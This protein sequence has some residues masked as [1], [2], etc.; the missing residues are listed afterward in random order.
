MKLRLLFI[1][2]LVLGF[3]IPV[4]AQS[5][6]MFDEV[7]VKIWPEYDKP[8]V[9]VILNMFLDSSVDLPA[10]M[11]VKIPAD[12]GEPY[13][14]AVRELDGML[15]L[16]E[17]EKQIQGDWLV[18]SFTTPYSEI[19]IEYYDP[20]I[21]TTASSRGY[22]FAWPGDYAVN[23]MKI[24]VQQPFT[25]SNMVFK[26]SMGNGVVGND[27][28]VYYTS[29]VGRINAGTSFALDFTYE[30]SDTELSAQSTTQQQVS[31]AQPVDN[32]TKGRLSFSQVF[33]WLLAGLGF[34]LVT[35]GVVWYV[36]TARKR[37]V[38]SQK[39]H[40]KRVKSSTQSSESIG[41]CHQ[42]GN[43]AKSGDVFCRSCGTRLRSLD[44]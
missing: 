13:S 14:V 32:Q 21:D 26:Q 6:I 37:P 18:L 8:A 16:L 4:Q 1:F 35:I 41:F 5:N 24:E 3:T 7:Q 34:I 31:A 17:Y 22:Q 2:V 40:T 39:R 36:Q 25:A 30:K 27:G 9:L 19:W 20:D 42:C 10:R 43:Q 23:S 33:P 38:P 12:V 11:N 29:D 28:L 44:E 15:Y